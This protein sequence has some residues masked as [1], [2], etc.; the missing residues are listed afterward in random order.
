M[1][2]KAQATK[3]KQTGLHQ[4]E[5]FW[6]IK[7]CHEHKNEKTD[8]MGENICKS[9]IQWRVNTQNIERIPKTQQQ[10]QSTWFKNSQK[11]FWRDVSP[12]KINRQ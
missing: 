7:G 2:S 6:Y 8:R 4:N 3:E 11:I 10:N 12:K 5:K 9:H 1:T